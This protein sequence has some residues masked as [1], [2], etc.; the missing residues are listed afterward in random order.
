MLGARHALEPFLA[1]VPSLAL[2]IAFD[3]SVTI[4]AHHRTKVEG[5]S[6]TGNYRL[7]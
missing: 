4:R 3:R 1:L 5:D 7:R 6:L 2:N